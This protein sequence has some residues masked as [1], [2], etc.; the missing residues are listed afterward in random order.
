MTK[1]TPELQRNLTNLLKLGMSQKY[2]CEACDIDESTFYLWMK[3]GKEQTRGKYFDFFKSVSRCKAQS[4]ALKLATLQKVSE[5]GSA[6]AV[7]W[8]LEKNFPDL[9]PP[10]RLLID[11]KLEHQTKEVQQIQFVICETKEDVDAFD[12]KH[13]TKYSP[14]KKEEA[15]D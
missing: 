3:Q 6:K 1:L 14:D 4:L 11:A 13:N 5:Q 12:K 8:W 7:I 10:E 15:P 2:A 9:Y